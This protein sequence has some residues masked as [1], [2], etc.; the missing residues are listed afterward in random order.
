MEQKSFLL[1]GYKAVAPTELEMN[2]ANNSREIFF[3]N[4]S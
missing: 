4:F 3:L 2:L 1:Q